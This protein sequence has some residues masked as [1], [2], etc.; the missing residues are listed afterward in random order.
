MTLDNVKMNVIQTAPNGVVN[1][2]T[3]FHFSQKDDFVCASY[4]GGRIWK[5]YLVGVMNQGK[6][7]F[8]YCQ[9]Q[10]DGKID[11]GQSECDVMMGEDGKLRL[12]EHFKWAS[13]N[14]ETGVNIFRE[15]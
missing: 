6:L 7:S 11:N 12:T 8:S 4:Q 13:K 14:D 5:G 3:I 2:L 1:D 15:L 10:T 9:L